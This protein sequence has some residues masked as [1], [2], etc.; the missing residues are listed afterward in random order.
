MIRSRLPLVIVGGLLALSV[1]LQLLGAEGGT[2][3][4]SD[5]SPLRST[6][7]DG[8]AAWVSLLEEQDVDV[9]RGEEPMDD[10][11]L[12]LDPSTAVFVLDRFLGDEERD[13]LELHAAGGVVVVAGLSTASGFELGEAAGLVA[14]V[15]R[16]DA[17]ALGGARQLDVT[18][19]GWTDLEPGVASIAGDGQV[20]AVVRRNGLV[21][22][23]SDSLLTNARLA[24]ADNAA[25]AIA[26]TGGASRVVVYHAPFGGEGSTGFASL[27]WRARWFLGGLCAAVAVA[28]FAIG[29]R[30]GPPQLPHREL[31]PPRTAYVD[32]LGRMIRRSGRRRRTIGRSAPPT[33]TST[34]EG[35]PQP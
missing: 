18:G 24:N 13:A 23:G 11:V 17:G 8:L 35:T 29:R 7:A 10:D 15:D 30:N 16:V 28:A 25:A 12:G 19:P 2:G 21:A 22:L 33:P 9:R 14:P 26:L 34:S 3:G 27:P 4:P 31:P 6:S 1:L 20:S 32:A 5:S